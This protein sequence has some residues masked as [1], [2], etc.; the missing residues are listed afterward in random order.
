[1][2][3]TGVPYR[4]MVF[5]DD[6]KKNIKTVQ[7]LG[8]CCIKVSQETGLTFEAVRSGLEKYRKLC[9]MRSKMREWFQPPIQQTGEKASGARK[10]ARHSE[11]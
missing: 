6:D 4:D 5:F 11:S 7:K 1:M 2:A 3:A 10:L 9:L 8:V